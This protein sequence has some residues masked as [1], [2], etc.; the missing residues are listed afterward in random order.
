[1]NWLRHSGPPQTGAGG[2]A[3]RTGQLPEG[4]DSAASG[5]IEAVA[6]DQGEKRAGCTG[7]QIGADR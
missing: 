3:S 5:A 4:P 6:Q 2:S 1:V 7:Q